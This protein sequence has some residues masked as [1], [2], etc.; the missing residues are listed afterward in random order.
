MTTTSFILTPK[1]RYL[2]ETYIGCFGNDITRWDTSAVTDMSYLFADYPGDIPDIS[3][4]NTRSVTNM[5]G[6]FI[7]YMGQIP[8]IAKR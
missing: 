6:M 3:R 7:R 5:E 8:N 2:H 4:W 1:L